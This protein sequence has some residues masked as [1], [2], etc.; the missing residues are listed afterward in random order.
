MWSN[1]REIRLKRLRNFLWENRFA[2]GYYPEKNGCTRGVVMIKKDTLKFFLAACKSTFTGF[3]G[4][5]LLR[6]K[7]KQE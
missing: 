4:L 6:R 1:V 7:P 2:A 5:L 3:P